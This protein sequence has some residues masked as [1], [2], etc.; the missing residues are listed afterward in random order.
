MNKIDNVTPLRKDVVREPRTDGWSNLVTLLGT[1][2]DKRTH[3][4]L[5]WEVHTPEFFEQLYSG[6]GIPARI[7]DVIPDHALRNWVS[8]TNLEGQTK[9][10]RQY[11]KEAIEER[12]LELDLR[13]NFLKTWK[14]GRAYGGACLHIVTDT[15]DPASPLSKG[16]KILALRDLSRWDLR[17]L[18]TD[19]EYDFGSPNYGH[20][21]IYYLNV[22]MGSQYKGYPIHWTRMIRFDG[23][24]VPRRTFIRNNYWHDSILNRVYNSIRNYEVSNDTVAAM[25][26]DFNVDIYKLNNVANL[27]GAGKEAV[28]KARIEMMNFTKSV[29]NAMILDTK[30]EEY[31]NKQ[32]SVEGV[33]ELLEMQANRLVADTDIPHTVLLGES[34]DGSNATG[35]ST[36]QQWYNF[37]KAEQEHVAKPKLNRLIDIIF[38]EL[39]EMRPH[40]KPLRVLDDLESADMRLKVAQTDQIYLENGVLDPTEITESRFGGD[41]Y[42]TETEIDEEG[43]ESGE[44]VPGAEPE[45]ENGGGNNQG[46]QTEKTKPRS[47]TGIEPPEGKSKA[48]AEPGPSEP[49]TRGNKP[50]KAKASADLTG[51]GKSGNDAEPAEVSFQGGYGESEFEPR[52]EMITM[53]NAEPKTKSFISQT[54]S[55]PMRDPRTDPRIKGP[56]IPNRARTILPTRG[57]GVMAPSGAAPE[58]AGQWGS[59]RELTQVEP[60]ELPD[61]TN[62]KKA[63]D[64]ERMDPG[65]EGTMKEFAKGTLK[66]S[67]GQKVTDPKQ[68]LAIGY[69]EERKDESSSRGASIIVRKGDAILFGRRRDNGR[70]TL[71][72]GHIAPLESHHQGAIRELKEETGIEAKKLKFIGSR[73]VEPTQGKSVHLNIYEHHADEDAKPTWKNDPDKEISEFRWVNS[74]AQLPPEISENLQHPNNVALIHLGLLK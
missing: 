61:V 74:K 22:Q 7:V 29:I 47:T 72:G 69:S 23:Q 68:A 5:N 43:R 51:R 14:W 24:L 13:G 52:N 34:P 57:T 27:I 44:I 48:D 28:I 10:Q 46:E 41:E 45:E 17:I 36:S 70:W 21:R 71:P 20:P 37:L 58:D 66:S 63:Y 65:V 67:S 59:P 50:R 56:G 35:N 42:S 1:S 30:D 55:E 9:Q 26:A 64:S 31:E 15:S 25:L 54:M 49:E 12:A 62:K 40:F 19:V 38:P 18:T 3:S 8:W 73:M 60:R 6:G 16:E 11:A 33:A 2:A 4:H 53:K 39:P 32:R